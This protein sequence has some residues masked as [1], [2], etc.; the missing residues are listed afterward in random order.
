MITP[1]SHSEFLNF[2]FSQPRDKM[3]DMSQGIG[4]DDMCGCLMVQFA[5]SKGMVGN[6]HCGY[7]T[8]ETN[9]TP[10]FK[11]EK[12]I[13]HYFPRNC[14]GWDSYNYGEIQDYLGS[15]GEKPS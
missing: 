4:N 12:P 13:F 6:I 14:K 3:V 1:V 7:Q 10:K 8:I 15:K 9:R 5:R 2:I 11:L